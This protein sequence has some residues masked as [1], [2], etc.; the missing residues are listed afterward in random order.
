V[1]AQSAPDF[2][3]K[4]QVDPTHGVFITAEGLLMYSEPGQVLDLIAECARR[5][6]GGR[7]LF[8]LPPAW[9]AGPAGRGRVF[10]LLWTAQRLPLLDPVRGVLPLLEFG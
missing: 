4:D 9:F 2:S 1:C 10:N 6:P 8:D 7:M 3:W 5:F